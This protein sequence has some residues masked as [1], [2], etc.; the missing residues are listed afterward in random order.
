MRNRD[1]RDVVNQW[2]KESGRE[3]FDDAVSYIDVANEL[4]L[5]VGHLIV[6]PEFTDRKSASTYIKW[7]AKQHILGETDYGS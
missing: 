3:P 1:A 6:P 2:L 5:L 7:T 4:R